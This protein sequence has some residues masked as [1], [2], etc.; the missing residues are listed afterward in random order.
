MEKRPDIES[1]C[2]VNEEC[3][4]F[5]QRGKGNLKVR[6]SYGQ[7]GI[8]YLRCRSCRK[9]FSE[10][11]GSALFNLKIAESKAASIIEHLDSRCGVVATA[12][13]VKVAKDTVSRLNRETG[14]V[15]KQLHNVKVVDVK[16]RVLQFDEKWSFTSKKQ[17]NVTPLDD[18]SEVGDHWDVNCIDPESKLLLTLVPGPRT[19]ATIEQA[20]LDAAGRLAKDAVIPAIIT[21]GESAYPEAILQAFGN[22]YPAPRSSNLGRPPAP[23][24][25]VPH[26]LVYAQVIKHRSAGRVDNVEIR[27]IFGKGKLDFIVE[28]LGWQKPNTSAIERFNLT[29][30]ARNARKARKSLT[31]SKK[32]REHDAMSFTSLLLYNFHHYHSSLSLR[33]ED[34]QLIKRTPAMAAGLAN[35]QFSLIELLRLS[36]IGY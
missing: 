31:W 24:L 33:T 36:P 15:S 29:D 18:I 27:P 22:K 25:R 17:K 20:V 28:M 35:K 6:K 14:K 8:R 4:E 1:L 34:G 19:S 9:E 21:D 7:D 13:L 32:V 26:D 3:K 11:R 5:G 12:K 10:R 30:R 16:P 23:I 2:C